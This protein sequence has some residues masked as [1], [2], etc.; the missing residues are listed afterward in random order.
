M[1]ELKTFKMIQKS[2]YKQEVSAKNSDIAGS[3]PKT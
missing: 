3:N 1:Q 2:M